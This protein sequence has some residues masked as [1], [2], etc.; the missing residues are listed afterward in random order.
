MGFLK[1]PL[2]ASSSLVVFIEIVSAVAVSILC[3]LSWQSQDRSAQFFYHPKPKETPDEVNA[4]FTAIVAFWILSLLF[5]MA[6]VRL[7]LASLLF[8]SVKKKSVKLAYI[9]MGV[10][11]FA[12]IMSIFLLLAAL[13]TGFYTKMAAAAEIGF[14]VITLY[15]IKVLYDSLDEMRRAND[16][17]ISKK[18]EL[19]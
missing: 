17:L 4:T 18:S 2:K 13:T 5:V 3:V 6:Y 16:H 10:K 9:W 15:Y 12:V 11:I 14:H 1:I 8:T 19:P 7:V